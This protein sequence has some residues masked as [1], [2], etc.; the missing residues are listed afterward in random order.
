MGMMAR[1]AL[2]I[3]VVLGVGFAMGTTNLPGGWYAGL[4]KPPFNPPSWVFAPVWSV[5]Y[6]L[7]ALAGA[8]TWER[9]PGANGP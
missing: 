5:V 6:V 9:A 8:R 7:I 3:L 4:V 2:F 1:A